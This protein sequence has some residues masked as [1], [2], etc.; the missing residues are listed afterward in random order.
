MNLYLIISTNYSQ[1]NPN[2]MWAI[3]T[4]LAW[5]LNPSLHQSS[6]SLPDGFLKL[7]ASRAGCFVG[8][9]AL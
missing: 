7:E 4:L 9:P 1:S 6:N 3:G 8:F 2:Q 5:K